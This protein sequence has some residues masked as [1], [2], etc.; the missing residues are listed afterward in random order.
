[1]KLASVSQALERHASLRQGLA[2]VSAAAVLAAAC[3]PAAAPPA[4]TRGASG[5]GN[6]ASGEPIKVGYVWGVTGAAAE[7]VRPASEATK[8]Y[9]DDL[10]AHGG[11][12]GRPVKMVE[13]DSKYQVPLAQEGYKKVTTEDNVPL[14]VLASTGDTEALA[15]QINT[16]RVAAVTFSCDEKWS[17]PEL[18]PYV[19]TICTTYQ[20]QMSTALK[21]IKERGAGTAPRVAFAYPD[22]P[23][24]QAPIPVGREYARSLGLPLVDEQKVGPADLDA[25]SQA[26]N[27]KSSNPDYVVVQ[28]VA[29]GAS[30]TVRSARQVGLRAQFLGLNYA[31]DE[32]TIQAIGPQAAEGYLGVGPNAFPGPEVTVVQEMHQRA[33]NLKGINMRSIAG[34]TLASVVADALQRADDFTGPAIKQALEGTDL[35]VKGAIPGSRWTY[36]GA[37]HVPTRKSVFYQVRNGRIGRISDPLD[38]PAR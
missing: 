5:A 25:Q 36:T 38:P 7:I 32:A 30:A 37:S 13:I 17:K 9:F 4:P 35:D 3:S 26:L 12:R 2:L 19:F 29:G 23:F 20:D 6:P 8:A 22:I 14:V 11:I 10:N 33:P 1:M 28:N 16:D 15:L 18:N 24:G 34:W 27:L 21:F 31:F